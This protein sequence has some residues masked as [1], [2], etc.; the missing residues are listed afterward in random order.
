LKRATCHVRGATCF[1]AACYVQRAFRA[2][3][4]M[5]RAHATCDVRR[6]AR[7]VEARF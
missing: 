6:A 1:R 7:D 2:T 4:N 3:C 5:Q